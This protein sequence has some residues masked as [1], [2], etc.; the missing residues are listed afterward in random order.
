MSDGLI[1]RKDIITDDALNWIPEYRAGIL[2]I[3]KVQ[4]DFVSSILALNEANSKSRSSSNPKELAENQK[5]T[6]D[7]A[8][9]SLAVL[10]QQTALENQLI[11]A[12][13]KN[14]LA[15]SDVAI[16]IQRERIETANKNKEVKQ[17]I[18][19]ETSAYAKLNNQRTAAKKVLLDLVAAQGTGTAAVK[20]AQ[21]EFDALDKK[22]K[23][24]DHS[25]KDFTKS[26]GDYSNGFIDAIEKTGLFG[27]KIGEVTRTAIGFVQTVGGVAEKVNEVSDSVKQGVR[28]IIGFGAATQ[29]S[30]IATT[31]QAVASE[32]AT[33]CQIG[34]AQATQVATVAENEQAVATTAL[35]AKQLIL[36]GINK[37]LTVSSTVMWAAMTGGISLL[38]VGIAAVVTYFSSM[39][40]GIDKVMSVF[41]PLSTLFTSFLGV[42]QNLGKSLVDAFSNPRKSLNE[43]YEFVK[44]NLINRFT[45][46][47]VI[48]DGIINL[49]FKKITNGALQAAT[50]V[51]NIT[52][53]IANAA[54]ETGK[55]IDKNIEKGKEIHKLNILIEKSQ[56]A[57]KKSEIE[58]G[59][60][61]EANLLISKDTSRSFTER[62][63]AVERIIAAEQ[64]QGDKA[65][66]IVE[67]KIKRLKVEQ[68]LRDTGRKGEEE[69]IDLQAE[70]DAAQDRGEDARRENMRVLSGLRKEQNAIASQHSKE[71]I[72]RD[73]IEYA[74]KYELEK[75]RLDQ[76]VATNEEIAKDEQKTDQER[77]NAIYKT[78]QAQEDLLLL[79]MQNQLANEQLTA[80]DRLRI[81]EDYAFKVEDLNK[82][83][84]KEVAKINEFDEAKY[85]K[86]LEDKISKQNVAMNEE[87]ANENKKF[88]AILDDEKLTQ[89]QREDAV[90]AH[91]KA[92]F[93]IKK[94]YALDAIQL[95]IDNFQS[96]LNASD[97]LVGNEALSVE[98]RQQLQEKLSKAIQ[99]FNELKV[100]SNQNSNKEIEAAEK[101]MADK[102][103]ETALALYEALKDLSNTLFDAK[104]QNI[105]N[106]ITKNNEKYDKEIEA[107]GNNESLKKELEKKRDK[108]NEE[109]EKKKREAQRKQAI[110]NKAFALAEIAFNTTK[111]VMAV[112]S[113][114]GGTYYADLGISAATLTALTIALGAAQAAAVIA[115]PIPKYKDGRKGGPAETAWVGDGGVSEVITSSKGMNPRLTPNIPTLTHL[116]EGDIVHK[117][118]ADYQAYMRASILSGL[119]MDNHRINDFQ[120]KQNSDLYGKELLEEL[121]RTTQAVK[122]QKN[123]SVINMP[124][125]DFNHHFWKKANTNWS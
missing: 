34:F 78:Q 68:S 12:K 42:V 21:A 33:V 61:I 114:G 18:I 84:V 115:T 108:E 90:K 50:G 110:L 92:I 59:N 94:K 75:Q 100:Q 71:Q 116:N 73:K 11:A 121:K 41:T 32:V 99:D 8:K 64:A 54:K 97:K 39:Q 47:G 24:A 122:G 53:K 22:V 46:F 69:M 98:K 23:E 60:I 3:T 44:N 76:I 49:D 85:T 4:K 28:N 118:M 82:K 62:A 16:A 101:E 95:Q 72:E 123:G 105:D 36:D 109:L 37:I 13:E 102:I 65:A 111:A 70:L 119:K 117:S 57:L 81:Q 17:G 35:G 80:N 25:A 15:T 124:G 40:E 20:K 66:A 31:E 93:D 120:M 38:I 2:E 58:T 74:S 87:L 10:K 19:E 5:K 14:K 51:E 48:L 9:N 88:K 1:T 55:F 43:L 7:I 63:K 112:A 106:E 45:A 83:V 30:T 125:L 104:I 6:N 52:G 27:G 96:E 29:I 86:D 107:A 56:N 113:T 91:E 77:I 26:V 67:N 89:K 79:A 103:R